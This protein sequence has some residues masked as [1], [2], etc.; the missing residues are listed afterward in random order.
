MVDYLGVIG[1]E[2][3][4]FVEILRAGPLDARV[5]GTPDWNLGE[6]G[7]HLI[8]VQRWATHIVETG[9]P[10]TTDPTVDAEHP[11]DGLEQSHQALIAAL[12]AADPDAAC[13]NFTPTAP[14][15]KAF[16]FRRQANE[17]AMHR[18]DAESAVTDDVTALAPEI[19]ADAID[20]FVHFMLPRVIQREQLDLSDLTTDVHVH[21]TDVEGEWTFE[22]VDQQL[23]VVAEHRKAAVAVRGPASDLVLFLYNRGR[24][25]AVEIFG[26]TAEFDRWSPVFGF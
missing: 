3:R 7:A 16:W 26:D 23:L 18:W 19:A 20:E 15:T 4:R 11:A 14:Q 5:P 6:L 10:P 21:C 2:S 17:V 25:D 9:T 1:T 8:D 22:V 24:S 13:W 12:E